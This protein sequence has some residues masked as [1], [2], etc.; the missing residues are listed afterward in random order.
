MHQLRDN[1]LDGR[2]V[3]FIDGIIKETAEKHS[4]V[5]VIKSGTEGNTAD[6]ILRACSA[7]CSSYE[8]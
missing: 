3:R 7:L 1:G 5:A 6:Q 8:R 4:S 2:G